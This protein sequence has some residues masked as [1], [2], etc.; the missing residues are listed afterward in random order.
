MIDD[1]DHDYDYADVDND[2][3]D[4]DDDDKFY[5]RSTCSCH[6]VFIHCGITRFYKMLI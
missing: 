6:V 2:N 4:V 1:H 5:H 3:D